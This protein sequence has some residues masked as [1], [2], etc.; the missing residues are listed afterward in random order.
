MLCNKTVTLANF[1]LWGS[2]FKGLGEVSF[3][4]VEIQR[5]IKKYLL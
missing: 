5:S 3:I 4:A 2:D 1:A